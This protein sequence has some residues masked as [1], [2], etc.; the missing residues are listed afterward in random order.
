ML[1]YAL[2]GDRI[3]WA[4]IEEIFFEKS[5]FAAQIHF[6]AVTITVSG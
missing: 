4:V 2:P 1:G 5:R 6:Y 3:S